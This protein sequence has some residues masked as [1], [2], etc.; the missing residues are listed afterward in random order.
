MVCLKEHTHHLSQSV[1]FVCF[2][3]PPPQFQLLEKSVKGAVT[4]KGIGSLKE[5]VKIHISVRV[6]V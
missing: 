1:E 6:R 4:I 3:F 2:F 5:L